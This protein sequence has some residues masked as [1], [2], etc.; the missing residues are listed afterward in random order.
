M[1]SQLP[2][3]THW[4]RV[5]SSQ[6]GVKVTTEVL[7]DNVPWDDVHTTLARF[8]WPVSPSY[9]SA[10]VFLFAQG[11]VDVSHAIADL[12][13]RPEA[14]DV[15]LAMAM[16]ARGV[17]A[18]DADLLVALVPVAFGR[19]LFEDRKIPFSPFA[20]LASRSGSAPRQIRLDEDPIFTEETWLAE[21][22]TLTR[23]QYLAVALRSPEVSLANDL[24]KS[25]LAP[26][27][28]SPIFIS[29]P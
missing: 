9:Y 16:I 29:I 12:V 28:V 4:V 18:T 11:G 5:F 14:D 23:E 20:M 8:P 1:D 19:L 24:V 26:A 13:S 15:D 3:G 17:D 27:A 6:E 7:L 22:G 21:C 2:E 10:R 25:G